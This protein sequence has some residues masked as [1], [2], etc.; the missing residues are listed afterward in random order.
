MNRFLSQRAGLVLTFSLFIVA[1]AGLVLVPGTL[2]AQTIISGDIA[3]TVTDPSGAAVPGATVTATDTA[4]GTVKVVKTGDAGAYR[5]SLLQPGAYTL[6]V[7]NEGFKTTQ[8]NVTVQ[9]GQITNGNVKLS[10]A[11][12]S[13]SVEVESSTVPLLQTENSDLSTTLT[14]QQ[15]QSLPNPGGDITYPVQTSQG[16]VMN[17]QGGNGS[18]SAFGLPATSNNFYTEWRGTE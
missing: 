15:V 14:M 9:V 18:S 11:Q 7:A 3:S 16:V 12:A 5:V 2:C 10:M 17:T 1:P 8:L 6:S 4:T 13:Q